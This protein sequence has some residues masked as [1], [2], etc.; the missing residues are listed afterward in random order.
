MKRLTMVFVISMVWIIAS[1]PVAARGQDKRIQ[2]AIWRGMDYMIQSASDMG[3]FEEH[4]SDYLFF[5]A[6]VIRIDDPWI[7]FQAGYH[8]RRLGRIYLEY[9]FPP[10]SADDVVDAASA[11]YALEQLGLDVDVPFSVLRELATQYSV[12]EYVGLLPGQVPNLD[13]LTDL[14]IGFYFT[15]ITKTPVGVSFAE[16]LY[17]LPTVDYQPLAEIGED[18][19]IDQNN[20][21]THLIY[22][23]SGYASWPLD[24]SL[25][26][27]EYAYIREQMPAAI[28]WAD[29]ETVSEFIDCLKIFGFGN[30]DAQVALGIELMLQMQKHDGRWEPD[31]VEDEYDRYHATWCVIDALRSYDQELAREFGPPDILSKALLAER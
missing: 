13:Q 12:D 20:F 26:A 7:S 10:T 17:Y 8:G 21:I 16:A 28:V 27:P 22:T 14:I 11:L 9:M 19:Y 1:G 18:D 30:Q 23:L 24:V 25:L 6:D 2:E 15:D 5:F 31:D 3:N 4:A 29:P